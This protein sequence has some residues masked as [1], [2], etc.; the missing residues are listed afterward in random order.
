M[1]APVHPSKR[2][3]R[4]LIWLRPVCRNEFFPAISIIQLVSYRLTLHGE[5]SLAQGI[6]EF[7]ITC[8]CD[9][10]SAAMAIYEKIRIDASNIK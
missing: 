1:P 10:T 5:T 2:F 8:H 6:L 9:R 4:F 7:N 3:K